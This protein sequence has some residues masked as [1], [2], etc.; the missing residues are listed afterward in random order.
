MNTQTGLVYDPKFLDHKTAD[1]PECPSRLLVILDALKKDSVLWNA[2]KHLYPRAALHLEIVRCHDE[3]LIKQIQLLCPK[4][5]G[6]YMMLDSD[7]V[8]S[9]NSYQVACLAAGA[10]LVAIDQI[11]QFAIRNAFCLVRPP[12]HHATSKHAMGFCLFNNAAI[13]AR[14]AQDRYSLKNVLIID[15]D[16]HHGNGTQEI[17]YD[18]PSVFYF[19]MHQYPF[20]PGGGH[21]DDI[22]S[23]AGIGTTL[24]IP[25]PANFS[26]ALYR[27]KFSAALNEIEKIFK[28]DLIIISAGFD[29]RLGDPLAHLQLTG[30]DYVEMTKEVMDLAER[31]C[32]G[33]IVSLLE[34]GY[35]T[36]SL[37]EVV[38]QHIMTLATRASP[39]RDF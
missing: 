2:L 18:D 24:N 37:G 34:G 31:V 28:P 35:V 12:G 11:M 3:A 26:A 17:F 23:S 21:S 14:Y 32:D 15:W 29:A 5:D 30:N 10:A 27:E 13:A 33:R 25:V 36:D 8:V 39:G 38:Y 19:S 4:Q 20:Y 22:G 1:S 16:V 9:K 7:T 6:F